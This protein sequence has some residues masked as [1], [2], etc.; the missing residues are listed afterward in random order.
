MILLIVL[1]LHGKRNV[2]IW[3]YGL[4][5]LPF[6][7]V[8]GIM[9]DIGGLELPVVSTIYI[10]D[11]W[12]RGNASSGDLNCLWGVAVSL[13]SRKIAGLGEAKDKPSTPTSLANPHAQVYMYMHLFYPR[14]LM[15]RLSYLDRKLKAS[16]QHEECLDRE[17]EDQINDLLKESSHGP[18]DAMHKPLQLLNSERTLFQKLPECYIISLAFLT[19]ELVDIEKVAISSSLRSLKPNN[20]QSEVSFTM[21]DGTPVE[22]KHQTSSGRTWLKYDESNANVLERFYTSA[23]NLV[24]EILL[25]LNLPDHRIL[26]DGGE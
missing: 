13:Y 8:E 12:K 3:D 15:Q 26:K 23:R 10:M 17:R 24:K 20:F 16:N 1:Y 4:G 18:S 5:V 6:D 7:Y 14:S 2:Y 25:K 19:P 21:T 11:I 9:C 22:S